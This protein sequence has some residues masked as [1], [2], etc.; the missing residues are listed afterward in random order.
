MG[1]NPP[2]HTHTALCG[3]LGGALCGALGGALCELQHLDNLGQHQ[4]MCVSEHD[5]EVTT[6]VCYRHHKHWDT[7]SLVW[8]LFNGVWTIPRISQ[9]EEL[10]ICKMWSHWSSE[11]VIPNNPSQA[12][13]ASLAWNGTM[14]MELTDWWTTQFSFDQ[15]WERRKCERIERISGGE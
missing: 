7:F 8:H 14:S 10:T 13:Q 6:W 5:W 1:I 11:T 4:N 2:S 15:G 3:A 12:S 9:I